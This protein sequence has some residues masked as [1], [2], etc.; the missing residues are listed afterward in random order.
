VV[1]GAGVEV[2]VEVEV[3]DDDEEEETSETVGAV[4]LAGDECFLN[5]AW[6]S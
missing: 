5:C 3:D 4:L 1:A 6:A 2:E